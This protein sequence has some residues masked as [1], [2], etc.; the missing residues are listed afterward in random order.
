MGSI[1]QKAYASIKMTETIDH[2]LDG[3]AKLLW[4]PSHWRQRYQAG[5]HQSS[6]T[7]P[8]RCGG[9][10]W[11][12]GSRGLTLLCLGKVGQSTLQC[13]ACPKFGPGLGNRCS[14]V[15]HVTTIQVVV[16][17]PDHLLWRSWGNCQELGNLCRKIFPLNILNV[18]FIRPLK[19][20]RTI[21]Y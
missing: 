1:I 21:I 19:R 8:R 12:V 14:Q 15:G 11:L 13:P 7:R 9:G 17:M 10:T 18:I 16:V 5:Q 2:Y 3:H 20:L 4:P 6:T